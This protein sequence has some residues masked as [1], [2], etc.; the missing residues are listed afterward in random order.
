MFPLPSNNSMYWPPAGGPYVQFTICLSPPPDW[1]GLHILRSLVPQWIEMADSF[2]FFNIDLTLWSRVRC[3]A[4]NKLQSRTL[5]IFLGKHAFK[6]IYCSTLALCIFCGSFQSYSITM[7]A[8]NVHFLLN[9]SHF[10]LNPPQSGRQ[11]AL[12]ISRLPG[13]L[14]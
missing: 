5:I 8:L 10:T 2:I 3:S 13:R 12:L 4:Q 9:I 7:L 6:L 14:Y 11:Q 1:L